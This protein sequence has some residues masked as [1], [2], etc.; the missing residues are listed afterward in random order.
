MTYEEMVAMLPDDLKAEIEV[1]K[2]KMRK[3]IARRE[4]REA[5]VLLEKPAKK[6]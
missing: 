3:A 4:K 6:D 1:E 2:E 5:N